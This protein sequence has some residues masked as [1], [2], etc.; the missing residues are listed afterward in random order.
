MSSQNSTTSKLA[1]TL[2]WSSNL[3]DTTEGG[4]GLVNVYARAM[5]NLIKNFLHFL[6][7]SLYMHTVFKAFLLEEVE[8]KALVRKPSFFLEKVYVLIKEAFSDM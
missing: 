6:H 8:S 7:K 4:L 3:R 2:L 5:A 1:V